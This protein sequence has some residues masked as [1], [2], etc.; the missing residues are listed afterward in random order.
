MLLSY[1]L[2]LVV[3]LLLD[4]LD[5]GLLRHLLDLPLQHYSCLLLNDL[6]TWNWLL[7]HLLRSLELLNLWLLSYLLLRLSNLLLE[8]LLLRL[9][10]LSIHLRLLLAWLLHVLRLGLHCL[11]W[12]YSLLLDRVDLHSF[13]DLLRL[14]DLLDLNRRYLLNLRLALL[15]LLLQL[16]HDLNLL[17][18][19]N[20]MLLL[21]LLLPPSLSILFLSAFLLIVLSYALLNVGLKLSAYSH[22][23]LGQLERIVLAFI[24]LSVFLHNLNY[25][26]GLI[27]GKAIDLSD[28]VITF[29]YCHW[30]IGVWTRAWCLCSSCYLCWIADRVPLGIK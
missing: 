14:L 17:P 4:L 2:L 27:G 10:L 16:W 13:L 9:H 8:C 26:F 24:L 1:L 19:W 7:H 29:S 18:A 22:W 5:V 20:L 3:L 12:L 6:L 11:L 30:C 28:Q 15:L 21:L 23:Q 25:S